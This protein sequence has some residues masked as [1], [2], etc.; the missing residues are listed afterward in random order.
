ML[1]NNRLM[2]KSYLTLAA[3]LIATATFAQRPLIQRQT[4]PS[5]LQ[6][7]AS[8]E[9][10]LTKAHAFQGHSLDLLKQTQ[11]RVSGQN[12]PGKA[13]EA[14]IITEQPEG[15]LKHNLYGSHKGYYSSF[16][17]VSGTY[18]FGMT[19]DVV[20]AADGSVYIKN[21]YVGITT[22]TWLKGTLAADG[23]TINVTL[24]QAI[25]YQE[26]DDDYEEL[27]GYA[28]KCQWQLVSDEEYGDYWWY[29]PVTDDNTVQFT[30]KDGFLSYTPEDEA[31]IGLCMSDGTWLG[32]GDFYKTYEELTEAPSSP[33]ANALAT[34]K[35][36]VLTHVTDDA[37]PDSIVT[38]LL[39]V[40]LAQEDNGDFYINGLG[41]ED[42]GIYVKATKDGDKYTV[43]RGQY[44]GAPEGSAHHLYSQALGW[45]TLYDDYYEEYYDSTYSIG[46][47]A[48]DYDAA[49][50]T[51][52]GENN[53]LAV[54]Y[55]RPTDQQYTAVLY[56]KPVLTPYHEV[57]AA[58][59]KPTILSFND[60][61]IDESYWW[62]TFN[63]S[64]KDKDGNALR[65]DRITYKIFFDDEE[66]T[67]YSDEYKAIGVE[68]M[69]EVPYAF[70]DSYDIYAS[71]QQRTIY[72]YNQGFGKIT[73]QEYYKGS[74]GKTYYS[75]P[76]NYYLSAEG[77]R[78]AA[79]SDSS[80]KAASVTYHDLA[81]RRIGKPQHGVY[82]K[83]TTLA[84]GTTTTSKVLVK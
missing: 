81:G 75:E 62:L 69:A 47:I 66:F 8:T 60:E 49:T 24:P 53:Y 1:E 46:Q 26:A 82:V 83:T 15:T 28:W 80:A 31:I 3:A 2:K 56:K 70:K 32:Y 64:N 23:Q 35:D 22:N 72:F 42:D 18:D 6:Q 13:P 63:L 10:P 19:D 29:V 84:D 33:S 30:Y 48:F 45:K 67:F 57:N 14:A 74:D 38:D 71:N 17:G 41:G 79:I 55:G 37:T 36:Y 59:A 9:A 39:I 21:P 7:H 34:A 40:K 44:L 50:D 77:I 73:L 20:F 43:A 76:E 58:P 5:F 12:A 51:Y 54:N 78:D 11:A 61:Y 16:Y 4:T 27:T 52:T 68:E 25:Y 65:S